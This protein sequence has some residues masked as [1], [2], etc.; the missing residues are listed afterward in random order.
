MMRSVGCVCARM[1]VRD[2]SCCAGCT[3][4][5]QAL[6]SKLV[7]TVYARPREFLGRC[8]ATRG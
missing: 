3:S 2:I 4:D 1:C 7:Y 8:T 6:A 5:G